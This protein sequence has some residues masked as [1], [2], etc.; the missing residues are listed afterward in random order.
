MTNPD[1]F[2]LYS[3]GQT[4]GDLPYF[5][6][7]Q[8]GSGWL[9]TIGRFALPILKRIGSFGMKTAKDII[10]NNGKVLPTLKSNAMAELGNV[11]SS[12][13]TGVSSMIPKVANM[14]P[15]SIIS[16]IPSSIS[17][18]IS[19]QPQPTAT[20]RRKSKGVRINKRMK[21]HGTIFEK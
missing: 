12:L 6:G 19:N 21:G 10:D 3:T 18:I 7:K 9:R 5:I 2:S 16:K 17:N 20:K 14:L 13:P 15:S 11:V 1:I 4:G 8:Y